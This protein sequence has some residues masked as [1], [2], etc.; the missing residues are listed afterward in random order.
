MDKRAQG[1][2]DSREDERI[3]CTAAKRV[4]AREK[5]IREDQRLRMIERKDLTDRSDDTGF[6]PGV[7]GLI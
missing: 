6:T 3:R 5:W 4:T 7:R 2:A 1:L